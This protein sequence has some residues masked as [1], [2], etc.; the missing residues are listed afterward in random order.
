MADRSEIKVDPRITTAV[1]RIAESLRA[2]NFV[3]EHGHKAI[4]ALDEYKE[5]MA[6]DI[7][8]CLNETE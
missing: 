8:E 3:Y 2:S 1:D 6:L 4:D 7:Q 5:D